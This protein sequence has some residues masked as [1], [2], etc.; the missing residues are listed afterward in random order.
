MAR[1]HRFESCRD[2]D[3]PRPYCRIW[4][5]AYQAGYDQG[6]SDGLAAGLAATRQS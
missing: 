4:K 5:D 1:E 6:F 2:A 3:C